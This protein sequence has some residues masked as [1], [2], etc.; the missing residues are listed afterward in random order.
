MWPKFGQ[1]RYPW[2][3]EARDGTLDGEKL[4]TLDEEKLGTLDGDEDARHRSFTNTS[5]VVLL[6]SQQLSSGTS[7]RNCL[8]WQNSTVTA[9]LLA[10]AGDGDGLGGTAL[11]RQSCQIQASLHCHTRQKPR[12]LGD[13]SLPLNF[14]LLHNFPAVA[15]F[16]AG[17]GV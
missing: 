8:A 1:I 14:F 15:C 5:G 10:I 17:A 7:G 2:W 4:G 3:R 12:P 13:L 11:C 9:P 16:L 6:R